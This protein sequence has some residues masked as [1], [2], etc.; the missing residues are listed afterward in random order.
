MQA[1]GSDRVRQDGE[2]WILSARREKGWVA[3][4]AKTLTSAEFPG[5]AVLWEDQYFE[6][7]A[8]ESQA[9][10]VRYVLEPWR[11]NN[12]IRVSDRYDDASEAAREAEYRRSVVREQQRKTTNLLAVLT[13]HLPAIVQNA[14]ASELGVVA[15]SIT[16]MSIIG[17]YVVVGLIA[18][19]CVSQVFEQQP[20]SALLGFIGGYLALE[21]TIRIHMV[22][23]QSRPVGS[24]A[25][26]IFYGIYYAITRRGPSP[27]AVEKGLAAPITTAPADVAIRDAFI[28][29]EPLVT[30]LTP[31]EQARMAQ[32]YEYDYRHHSITVALLILVFT[33]LGVATAVHRGQVVPGVL[34]GALAL[35]QIMRLIAFRRGPAASVLRFLARPF[36]HRL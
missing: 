1:Y 24:V 17:V 35:E 3:R 22:W 4:V 29:R 26:F 18:M 23:T 13:G 12:T 19:Y 30:L 32:R 20:F 36:L 31:A 11:D 16:M 14:M 9:Y 33:V 25:G 28:L 15:T 10:G 6:V 34:A 8:L 2:R 5:T 27:F 7:V 21:N